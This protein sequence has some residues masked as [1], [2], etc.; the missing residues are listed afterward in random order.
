MGE[1][2]ARRVFMSAR[3]FD[4]K[5]ALALNI[6]ADHVSSEDIEP[7]VEAEIQPYLKVAPELWAPPR[8]WPAPWVRAL[9]TP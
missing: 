1:G 9:M 7:R 6:I 4:A 5:E 8:P 3:L 2:K